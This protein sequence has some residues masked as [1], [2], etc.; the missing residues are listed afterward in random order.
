MKLFSLIYM[1]SIVI[2]W[3]TVIHGTQTF[4]VVGPALR[5]K[6]NLYSFYELSRANAICFKQE[7]GTLHYKINVHVPNQRAIQAVWLYIYSECSTVYYRPSD[8][9]STLLL[10]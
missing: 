8:K 7:T 2:S 4:T 1:Y 5:C 6:A 10:F 3:F 9:K